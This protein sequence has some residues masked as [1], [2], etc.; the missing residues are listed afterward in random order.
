[1]ASTRILDPLVGNTLGLILFVADQPVDVVLI[2]LPVAPPFVR[3]AKCA[4]NQA[5]LH[6]LVITVLITRFN[7]KIPPT[8]RPLQLLLI[9]HLLM[10]PSFPTLVLPTMSPPT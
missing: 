4:I 3:F 2:I 9:Q 6:S 7:R 10:E 1:V 5:T 8:Y